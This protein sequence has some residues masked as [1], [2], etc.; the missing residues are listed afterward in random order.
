MGAVVVVAATEAERSE[1]VAD[2]GPKKRLS[3]LRLR[4]RSTVTCSDREARERTVIG[5]AFEKPVR[6]R[7]VV[8]KR[9]IHTN[10]KSGL[11][12]FPFCAFQISYVM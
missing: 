9:V 3:T 6:T 5:G 10:I 8:A 7:D 2:D 4:L 11:L 1:E 12:L